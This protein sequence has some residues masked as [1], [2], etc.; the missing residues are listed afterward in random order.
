MTQ[1][2]QKRSNSKKERIEEGKDRSEL[3]LQLAR[4][5]VWD[6]E[7]FCIRE[8]CATIISSTLPGGRGSEP[9]G[10]PSQK[11]GREIQTEGPIDQGLL[12]SWPFARPPGLTASNR[13]GRDAND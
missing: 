10:P 9:G 8:S 5:R 6:V 4:E 12:R 11:R 1:N 3:D 2:S 7:P 13:G